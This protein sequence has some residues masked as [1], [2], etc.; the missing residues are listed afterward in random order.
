L[1]E[2]RQK[3]SFE[4]RLKK[5][6]GTLIHAQ[7]E[8]TIHPDSCAPPG[9]FWMIVSDVS[10]RK[11]AELAKVRRLKNRYRAIVMD[12]NDLIVR[13]DPQGKI[14][15]VNDAYCRYFGVN[16]FNILGSNFLPNIHEE[17]LPLVREYFN[18]L[19]PQQPEKTIEHRVIL[20]DGK[21]YWQQWC[22]RAICDGAGNIFEYQAVGRDI[23]KLKEAEVKLQKQARL[24]Q[25]FLDALPCVALLLRYNTR[26][27]VASNKTAV[28]IGAIP[29][30]KCYATWPQSENPCP[31]CLAPELWKSGE[32][33]SGQFWGLG[34]YWDAHWIPVEGDL[35]LHYAFDITENQQAKEALK[36]TKDELEQRV[37]ERT[38]ELQKSHKQLLHSEKLAAVGN[39]SASIAHEF[40]NPLQSIMS[41]IKGIGKYVPMGKNEA[42]LVALALQECERMK[43]L[44]ASLRDFFLPTSGKTVRLDLHSI[45]DAILLIAK[46]DFFT[47]KIQVKR[48]YGGKIPLIE[49]VAD[50]IKQV[51]LNILNNA[52]DACEG[53]G[54]ITI[55]TER[56]GRDKVV[57]HIE[58][59]GTGIA[60]ENINQIFDPFF[61]TKPEVKGTGLGLSVSYGIIK[62]HGGRIEVKSELGKGSIFS[63][64]LPIESVHNEQ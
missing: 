14:T 53:E 39:L 41:I 49:A 51:L 44:I 20:G 46:K 28:A 5:N 61:T 32:A 10:V 58:D 26:Q 16:H 13:F 38:V 9:Q 29:G 12:Q 60:T 35:Y 15:F 21:T 34:R 11:E 27:I 17:D 57:V 6:D 54:I 19:N 25:L 18:N 52:A 7:F 55:T 45:I 64:F 33:Q 62:K 50:Q 42:E 31:W 30:K 3:Q 40:N 8:T 37:L 63:V 36:K 4:L 22:R 24:Q 2:T 43:N 56:I 59:N 48:R 47:R 23:S 1:L